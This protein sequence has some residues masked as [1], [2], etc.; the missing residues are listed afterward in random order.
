MYHHS[1]TVGDGL[2]VSLFVS[3]SS[4]HC[5]HL[6]ARVGVA[7]AG[8]GVAGVANIAGAGGGWYYRRCRRFQGRYYPTH[9]IF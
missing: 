4:R 9:W 3:L 2:F 6:F 7:G 5:M 8:V 1:G